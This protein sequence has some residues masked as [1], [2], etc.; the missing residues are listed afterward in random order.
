MLVR[1][2]LLRRLRSQSVNC[3]SP[4]MVEEAEAQCRV[5]QSNRDMVADPSLEAA[6]G[7]TKEVRLVVARSLKLDGLVAVQEAQYMTKPRYGL[8]G[9]LEGLST[10]V[11]MLKRKKL[12]LVALQ[13]VPGI[14]LLAPWYDESSEN[15]DSKGC[16]IADCVCL[17]RKMAFRR[18]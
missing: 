12:G 4:L 14:S 17:F 6:A 1:D 15:V 16:W 18:L 11:S 8:E 3:R 13:E 2:R 9:G 5:S 7:G 10:L